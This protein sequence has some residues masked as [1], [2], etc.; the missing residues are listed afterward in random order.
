MQDVNP[1]AVQPVEQS[2]PKVLILISQLAYARK[3]LSHCPKIQGF[4]VTL[5]SV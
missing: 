2:V 5:K 3:A 1:S 4:L